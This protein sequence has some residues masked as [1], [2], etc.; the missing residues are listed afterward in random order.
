MNRAL[1]AALLA[2][3]LLAPSCGKKEAGGDAPTKNGNTLRTPSGIDIT[4]EEH[5]S[6]AQPGPTDVVTVH[7]EGTFQDGRV[8][9]SSIARG[10]PAQ[11]PLNRVIPCWT[12][13]LQYLHV[14]GKA[15]IVCP[16]ELAYGAQGAPP[17]IPPNATL[18]F[19][20]QLLGVGQAGS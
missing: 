8:F 15:R 6:G 3:L 13:A 4:I 18:I 7:Y 16:P 19:E 11:F 17:T 2:T 10:T 12:E 20:V 9:D 5:G 1:C 14:G